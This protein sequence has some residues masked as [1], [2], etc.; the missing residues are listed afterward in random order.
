MKE[1]TKPWKC[2]SM[3]YM[4]RLDWSCTDGPNEDDGQPRQ[5]HHPDNSDPIDP[6]GGWFVIGAVAV[7]L[8]R[9]CIASGTAFTL[10]V[11]VVLQKSALRHSKIIIIL[12][13]P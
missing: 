10:N 13:V 3:M 7:F 2:L 11:F 8:L 12:R 9:S 5:A 4:P 1:I 6:G